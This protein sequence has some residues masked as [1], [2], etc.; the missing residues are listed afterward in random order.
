VWVKDLRLGGIHVVDCWHKVQSACALMTGT[1][2]TYKQLEVHRCRKS[3]EH[4]AVSDN[5]HH[6][7]KLK[8]DSHQK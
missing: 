3:I 2:V 6:N 8:P 4:H 1:S 7:L 5:E